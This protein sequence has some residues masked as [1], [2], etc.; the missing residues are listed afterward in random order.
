MNAANAFRAVKR[1]GRPLKPYLQW[2][3]SKSYSEWGEDLIL[4]QAMKPSGRG[5][6]V[7]VGAY[8][9]ITWSN[10]YKLYKR[11]WSGVTIEP[12]LGARWKFRLMRGRDT[13]LAMGASSSPTTLTYHRF[14]IGV[15]NTMSGER[16]KSLADAGYVTR[17]VEE[18]R[19]DRLDTLLNEYAPGRHIDMLTVDCEGDDLGVV[20]T[21]DFVKQRPTVVMVEDLAGFYSQGEQQVSGVVKFMRE[22]G[23]EPISRPSYTAIF[24]ARDWRE[25]NRR[26]GAYREAAIHP[27]ILP[28]PETEPVAETVTA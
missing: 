12:D 2:R 23:Y 27:N 1:F 7:D 25:L 14:E 5:F 22:R 17:G 26:S 8:D 10:T 20:A 21:L 15:L 19:C 18:V 13:H 24:V 6:Y 28:E 3:G 11:G 9:P 16:A 4:F